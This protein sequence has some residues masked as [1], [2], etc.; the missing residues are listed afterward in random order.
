MDDTAAGHA[1]EILL[2]EHRAGT[3]FKPFGPPQ[4]PATMAD[5]YDIQEKYVALLRAT[6]GDTIG[7]KVGLTSIAMQ[8]FCGIDHPIA[9]VVLASRKH[10][11]GA[12]A[13]RA[14]FGR[15]GLE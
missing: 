4:G 8:Q 12:T 2:A 13:R 6:Q 10:A 14:A 1:A 3:R 7:Y 15:F 11:S 5:G 9:G